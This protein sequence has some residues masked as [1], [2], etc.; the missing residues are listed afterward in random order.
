[1]TELELAK[2]IV[3]VLDNKKAV[4]LKAIHITEFSIVADYFIIAT[5]TSNTHVKALA[6]EVEYEMT[7]LGIEPSHI[8][9]R[10]TGW[11]LLDYGSVVVHVFSPESR[12]YYNL[13]RLWSDAQCL[14]L[15]DIVSE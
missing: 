15:S 2:K 5:G 8:E 6:E 13:E 3:S 1:M 12:E 14:D 4:D 10:A 9:G 11:I 7:Q